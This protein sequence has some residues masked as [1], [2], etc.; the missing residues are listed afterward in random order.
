MGT[1]PSRRIYQC[2]CR[3]R[4]RDGVHRP[5]NR[6]MPWIVKRFDPIG[7]IIWMF[8]LCMGRRIYDWLIWML[9]AWRV[10]IIISRV[11][12][13]WI[14]ARIFGGHC[15][16]GMEGRI[17]GHVEFLL[18]RNGAMIDGRG[19][20]VQWMLLGRLTIIPCRT[21]CNGRR[22]ITQLRQLMVH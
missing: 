22:G 14:N 9:D 6:R 13:C 5:R 15:T 4:S 16:V 8:G 19:R 3:W 7:R 1:A 12:G 21:G 20:A 2:R 18:F 10:G 17:P 11:A